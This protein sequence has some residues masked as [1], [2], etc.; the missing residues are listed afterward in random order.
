MRKAKEKLS[1]LAKNIVRVL[2]LAYEIDGKLVTLYYITAAF[3]AITPILAAYLF[4]ISIDKIVESTSIAGAQIS[5]PL[6]I[7]FALA[8]YFFIHLVETVSYWGLNVAYYDYLLRNKFQAGLNYRYSKKLSS[9]DLGHL[10]S[11]E[12]QNLITKVEQ[13]FTWQIPDFV[14]MWNYIFRDLIGIISVSIALSPYSIWIPIIV[15]LVSSPRIYLKLKHGN[16]VWS[17]YGGSAPEAKKLWYTGDLLTSTSSI[18]ET[19]IF[20]SQ[21]ALLDRLLGLQDYL[22]KINK[23]PLDSYRWVLIIAP[24]ME[25]IVVF[26]LV[27]WILPNALTG[28]LTI[29]S[30]TFIIT[31]LEQLR[32]HTSWGAA[33]FGELYEHSLFV[34]PY[35]ELM[36][37]PKLIKEKTGAKILNES[38]PPKIEFK[39]VSFSYPNGREVLK[40]ISFT[41]D[42]GER[43]ALVGVNGA[44][45]T[46]LIKLL[47]RFYDVSDGEILINGINLKN[48][49]LSNWYSYLGTLF[50]DFVKYNFTVRDNIMLGAPH[51]RDEKRMQEAAVQSGAYDFIKNFEKGYDQML[52]RRF[53]DGEELSGGQWQKLAIARTFYEKA[54]ILIMD[55]PTSAIDAE[56]EYEIFQNLEKV[57]KNKTLILV[58]HRF[59]TVRNANKIVVIDD[60]RI[61]E[62]GTHQ[63]LLE[64][65]GKYAVMFN[66]QA[67]GY[68]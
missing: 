53:E 24:L 49:K 21:E 61:T 50:Q 7:V 19:R 45:K 40:D 30:I 35:F 60:G 25:S 43:V 33:H 32:G 46:T 13:T 10:E 63:E 6:V 65:N 54:P 64:C 39:K 2:K 3:G 48:I 55:E 59:S 1:E 44:G 67:K 58:S 11:P 51:I 18:I 34:N 20:Q 8:G 36:A 29:G 15:L 12:V 26:A 4:K 9:L 5:V 47:C 23:K 17:M 41:I 16:F 22:Y 31:T 14:R 52:G 57:Y 27:Y 42:S 38:K 68:Q 62:M 56:S 66:T 28:A 37:L